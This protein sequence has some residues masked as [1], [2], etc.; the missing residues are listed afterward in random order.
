MQNVGFNLNTHGYVRIQVL[1]KDYEA[2]KELLSG[3]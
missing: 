3:S 1:P 2:A